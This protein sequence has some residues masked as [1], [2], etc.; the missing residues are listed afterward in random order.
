MQ[1]ILGSKSVSFIL[2]G[3]PKTINRES[4][5]FASVLEAISKD[6]IDKLRE[7]L[8]IKKTIV[9]KVSAMGSDLVRVEGNKVL[10]G[11]REITGLITT[12]IFE[13]LRYGLS[14]TPMLNFLSRLMQNPSKRAV[15]EVFSFADACSLPIT[16]DGYLLAYR[17][18]G[19]NYLDSHSAS[20]LSKPAAIMTAEEKAQ[21]ANPVV[22]GKEKNVTMQIVDDV[23]TVSMP[24]NSVDEDKDRTC[25][26]G[27]H[28]CS[29]AYLSHFS[30]KHILVVKIDPADIVAIPSDYNNAKGRCSK[31]QVVDEITMNACGVAE[32]QI[33]QEYAKEVIDNKEYPTA[34]MTSKLAKEFRAML[35]NTEATL[36]EACAK[37]GISRRQGA[38]IRDFEAWVN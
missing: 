1:Y 14:I 10:Y 38:R 31:Y 34:K 9:A 3:Q 19:A 2:D 30:G 28:F 6:Q 4:E 17:K 25:S 37:F 22:G 24:R 15:D 29:F 8:Q 5:I 7:M 20:V 18:N 36:T 32:K 27:L 12:R 23:L 11:E 35:D 13:M 33:T 21:Y 16:E 26:K